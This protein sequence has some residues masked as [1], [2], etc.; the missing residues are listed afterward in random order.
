MKHG[1]ILLVSD[2]DDSAGDSSRCL[3]RRSRSSKAHIPV[4]IVPLFA[5]PANV[6]IFAG[7]FGDNAFVDPSV[8]T[9]RWGARRSRWRR[10]RPGR[11]SA[12]AR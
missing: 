1:S 11:C 2:L 7:L 10:R 9:H 12:S 8:F 4:R 5:D 3:P 6:H